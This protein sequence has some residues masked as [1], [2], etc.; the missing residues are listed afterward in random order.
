MRFQKGIGCPC[1]L[2]RPRGPGRGEY[3]MSRAAYQARVRNLDCW[4]RP[5]TYEETRR[6][7]I[8]IAL[9]SHRREPFRAVAKRLG[10]RS[11]AH[12]WRTARKYRAGR[13]PMLPLTE[14]E[15]V[16]FHDSLYADSVPKSTAAPWWMTREWES[17][18]EI[19]GCIL[20]TQ[21]QKAQASAELDRRKHAREHRLSS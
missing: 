12:C 7:E 2:R 17:R 19:W 15:L 20:L 11:Y 21:E 3:R 1:L 14:P 4:F 8:E 16:A 18:D 6:I 5:R 10:L 13:L 9:A